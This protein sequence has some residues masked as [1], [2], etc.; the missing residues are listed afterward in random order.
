MVSWLVGQGKVESRKWKVGT[1]RDIA[2]NVVGADAS[3]GPRGHCGMLLPLPE[4]SSGG[5]GAV[6][7]LVCWLGKS[8]KQKVE[9]WNFEWFSQEM[10][11]GSGSGHR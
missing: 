2:A 1:L 6:G 4:Q 7:L 10:G 9:S 11:Y 3:V 8:R 5:R